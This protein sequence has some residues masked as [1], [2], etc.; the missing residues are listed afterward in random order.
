MHL[1]VPVEFET[2]VWNCD[3]HNAV[4]HTFTVLTQRKYDWQH[5]VC[6]S[7]IHMS[8]IQ[9]ELIDECMFDEFLKKSRQPHQH[10]LHTMHTYAHCVNTLNES[11]SSNVM[12]LRR[13]MNWRTKMIWNDRSHRVLAGYLIWW[14]TE[15][16][17]VTHSHWRWTDLWWWK[18]VSSV[19][20][21]HR[22]YFS[23]WWN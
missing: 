10:T 20:V 5:C 4:K 13:G 11:W 17:T 7:L 12:N 6:H 19:W 22:W 18:N 1:W 15:T 8:Q 21:S 2:C 16:S 14:K 3:I 23:F 9:Q